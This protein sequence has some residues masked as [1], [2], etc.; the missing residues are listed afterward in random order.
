M[1]GGQTETY[2]VPKRPGDVV[3]SHSCLRDWE[4]RETWFGL[5]VLIYSVTDNELV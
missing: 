4:E 3:R 2:F 1:N 5:T